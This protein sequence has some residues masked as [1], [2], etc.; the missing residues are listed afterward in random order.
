MQVAPLE[1]LRIPTLAAALLALVIA[2]HLPRHRPVAAA[3]AAAWLAGPVSSL[4]PGRLG[5]A[6]YMVIPA[7]AAWCSLRVLAGARPSRA[8][9]WAGLWWIISAAA[10][11]ASWWLRRWLPAPTLWW[12]ALP[13][14]AHAL[15]LVG[16]LGAAVV[17][18][19][20]RGRPTLP[21]L[22]ALVLAF[23]DAFAL[24]GPVMLGGRWVRASVHAA[25]IGLVLVV[26]QARYL[27][28]RSQ[29]GAVG[30]RRDGS[31]RPRLRVLHRAAAPCHGLPGTAAK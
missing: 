7:L 1:L 19:R 15:A 26:L 4:A 9:A 18:W 6:V 2:R 24:L 28:R 10:L 16:Q 22:C 21:V 31:P 20:S 3:L 11:A 27:G 30:L 8:A 13:R 25:V 14:T 12:A 17:W 23:G 29:P 5:M